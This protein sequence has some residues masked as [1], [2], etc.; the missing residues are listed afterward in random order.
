MNSGPVSIVN[1]GLVTSVG[2]TA[3]ASCA[4]IRAGL[5]NPSETQFLDSAGDRIVA[6]GVQLDQPWRGRR[7]LVK[8]AALAIEECLVGVPR[9]EWKQI[10]LLLCVAE[11]DRPGRLEGLDDKLFFEIQQDL[12]SEFSE[13][14]LVIPH[15]RVSVATAMKKARELI[16]DAASP[17][18]LIAATD[19]LLTWP[20]LNA[21]ERDDRLLTKKNSNGFLPGEGAGALLIGTGQGGEL[22]VCSGIGFATESATVAG[23]EP[24]R[25]SGLTQAIKNALADAG[26]QISDLD[27]RITDASGEQYYFKEAALALGRTLKSR[28]EEFKMW[29]PAECVGETG[30]TF[31][32]L[33]LCVASLAV[34]KQYALGARFLVHASADAGQRMAMVVARPGKHDG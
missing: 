13:A 28:K 24:L 20:T 11:R 32:V 18:V 31:G 5:T 21:F 27:F 30:A 19:S 1:I 22:L 26:C 29:H 9:E 16:R 12:G 6:H 34:V 17:F 2:L 8:M 10:P 7:K 23:G 14:S 25:G 4:A 3:A 33:C 15:G